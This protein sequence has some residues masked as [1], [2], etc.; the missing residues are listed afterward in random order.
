MRQQSDT[1]DYTDYSDEFG[2]N[3]LLR[4]R[5]HPINAQQLQHLVHHLT[6][7]LEQERDR[8]EDLTDQLVVMR[9]NVQDLTDRL[10]VTRSLLD[11]ANSDREYF[12]SE[13]EQSQREADHWM[14]RYNELIT[15]E[16]AF[17][18]PRQ[19]ALLSSQGMRSLVLPTS[20]FP[21]DIRLRIRTDETVHAPPD[22]ILP[23][24]FF[25]SLGVTSDQVTVRPMTDELIR[26]PTPLPTPQNSVQSSR[27]S[28]RRSSAQS[29]SD[30][31]RPRR[32]RRSRR[33]RRR[34]PPDDVVLPLPA[35]APPI[36]GEPLALELDLDRDDSSD[37]IIELTRNEF[38]RSL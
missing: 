33:L 27:R 35:P 20:V 22:E 17:F 16:F 4:R 10:R 30:D 2:P 19:F 21:D 31:E 8:N 32:S 1:S 3:P 23:P 6:R 12:Q 38:D 36:Q 25:R 15:E 14:D 5:R 29:S 24:G 26:G 13:A 34:N 9:H 7:Q 28:S 18:Q 11:S 37:D